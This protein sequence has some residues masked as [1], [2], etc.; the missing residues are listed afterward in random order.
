MSIQDKKPDTT[1]LETDDLVVVPTPKYVKEAI[2]EHAASRNHPDATLQDKGFVVLSNDTGSDSETMAATPKAVKA[3]Y[4][5]ANTAN[6]N[7]LNNNFDLYLEKKQNGDDIPNKAEFV[8]NIG[9]SELVY[10]TV[11]N[12]PN[13]IPDMSFFKRYGD[14]QNGWVQYPNGLIYQWGVTSTR[15]YDEVYITF[16]I[17]FSSGVSMVSE[18]DN[19]GGAVRAIWQI[20]DISL[21]GFLA[22]NLGTLQRGVGTFNPSALSACQWHAW[23]F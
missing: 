15:T 4:D 21:A 7:A 22:I 2:E 6:Q 3:A 18:H 23:G 5:L 1:T 16:P 8:K 10:R 17:Q 11:G 9:L 19:G 20:N 12:G 13:Q 14:A